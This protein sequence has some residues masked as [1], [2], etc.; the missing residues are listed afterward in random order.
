MIVGADSAEAVARMVT[1]SVLERVT[2][3]VLATDLDLGM[4]A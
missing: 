4:P 1:G 2:C 3:L